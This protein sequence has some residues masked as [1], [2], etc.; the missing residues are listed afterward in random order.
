VQDDSFAATDSIT[1]C[2]FTS[3]PTS[4]PL[5]RVL[6]EPSAHNG[7]RLPCSLMADKLTTVP[8]SKLGARVGRLGEVDMARLNQ[9]MLVFLGM[10]APRPVGRRKTAPASG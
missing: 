3:D 8:R 1:L 5:F 7:L 2:A 9:A 10:A 4:A 6:V